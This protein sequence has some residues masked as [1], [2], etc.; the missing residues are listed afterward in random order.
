LIALAFV[1]GAFFSAVLIA[2]F[3]AFIAQNYAKHVRKH[4]F[5]HING[6]SA[7][8]INKLSVPSLITRNTSDIDAAALGFNNVI[9][10]AISAPG[11]AIGGIIKVLLDKS[12]KGGVTYSSTMPFGIIIGS[13]IALLSIII[14][15]LV[16]FLLPRFKK[17]KLLTDEANLQVRENLSGI[18]VV[19]AFG[20][21]KKHTGIYKDTIE[22]TYRNN[23]ALFAAFDSA[24]ALVTTIVSVMTIVF[25]LVGSQMIPTNASSA[26]ITGYIAILTKY[27]ILSTIIVFAFL[28]LAML[29]FNIPSAMISTKRINEVF[30]MKTNIVNGK[31]AGEIKIET[32]EFK[33]VSFKFDPNADEVVKNISFK[34]NAGE[35]IAIVGATGC[36]KTSVLSL[37]PRIY[38][39]TSGQILINNVDIKEYDVNVVR[40]LIGFV[41]QKIFLF[42]DTVFNNI[43]NGFINEEINQEEIDERVT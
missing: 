10:T 13:A 15:S 40:N 27:T 25:Y 39:V 8:Q 36:G 17:S 26:D 16:K 31:N 14:V 43:K 23:F 3:S 29:L 18:R 1:L 41:P 5:S 24:F 32:I 21:Q 11:V 42:G 12:S 33:N 20:M 22:R 37:I 4:L 30:N 38:D 19:R 28:R 2:I 9:K 35:T 7:D 6:L 34:V